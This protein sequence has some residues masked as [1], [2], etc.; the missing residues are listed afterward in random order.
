MKVYERTNLAFLS[1]ILCIS[2]QVDV[3]ANYDDTYVSGS[4]AILEP[5]KL[6]QEDIS[7]NP[8]QGAQKV[9]AILSGQSNRYNG[10][11]E[12]LAKK[13]DIP[14]QRQESPLPEQKSSL[15][16]RIIL[17]NLHKDA[18]LT[19]IAVGGAVAAIIFAIARASV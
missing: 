11:E 19:D 17:K 9:F 4:T 18:S 10:N 6:Q 12:L 16:E 14:Q 2:A 13:A 8:A 7:N 5:Q 15:F 1:F 3:Q